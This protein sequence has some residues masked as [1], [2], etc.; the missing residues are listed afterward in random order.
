MRI[1]CEVLKQR[2]QA[3][4][5]NHVG[6]AL[7]GTW[8]Q[9]GLGGFFRGTGMTLCREL[10]FYVAGSGL[11]AES[12]KVEFLFSNSISFLPFRITTREKRVRSI[13]KRAKL[14]LVQTSRVMFGFVHLRPC[15]I[16]GGPEASGTGAGALG[17]RRGRSRIGQTNCRHDNSVRRDQDEDDD[18]P[19]RRADDD[20]CCR[21]LHFAQ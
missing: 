13:I 19:P 5:F 6:E 18:G 20:V 17:D 21:A 1:P 8:Q 2:L 10:P 16:S 9:D 12:K 14:E 11:Y 4:Q 7:V 15:S 3:G